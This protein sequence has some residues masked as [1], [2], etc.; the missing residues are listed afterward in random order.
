MTRE[1]RLFT[2]AK[3]RAAGLA[4]IPNATKRHAPAGL[5]NRD[6]YFYAPGLEFYRV[7][8]E[9]WSGSPRHLRPIQLGIAVPLKYATA[10][11]RAAGVTFSRADRNRVK[12]ALAA[13]EVARQDR[14]RHDRECRIFNIIRG[15]ARDPFVND[16]GGDIMGWSR[17]YAA[18]QAALAVVAA[19]MSTAI[20]EM[21]AS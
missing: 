3:A 7:V 19:Q 17:A 1:T 13:L 11:A 15:A 16:F 10:T 18:H 20:D 12:K 6:A 9:G 4:F 5:P 2:P 14:A 21:V 8:N